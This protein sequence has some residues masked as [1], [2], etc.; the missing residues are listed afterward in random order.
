M[1]NV[2][3]APSV[4]EALVEFAEKCALDNGV[5]CALHL[6]DSFDHAVES[7]KEMPHRGAKNLEYI[8]KRYRIITF[9][10]HLWLVYQIG[11]KERTVFIDYLLD[12]R[13]DYGR[14]FKNGGQ[15]GK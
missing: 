12:D 10:R 3:V 13:S 8:P 15:G 7:L 9:W 5:E 6:A 2:V 14:L 1:Y 4:S 11:E